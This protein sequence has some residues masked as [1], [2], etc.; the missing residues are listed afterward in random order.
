MIFCSLIFIAVIISLL[1]L[2]GKI[3]LKYGLLP[4]SY[5]ILLF[6]SSV[7]FIIFSVLFFVY[8]GIQEKKHRVNNCHLKILN[9]VI[10]FGR[11][12]SRFNFKGLQNLDS[13]LSSL[14]YDIVEFPQFPGMQRKI[15]NRNFPSQS[16]STE[17]A[18]RY[19]QQKFS[20]LK[21]KDSQLKEQVSNFIVSW[22]PMI[23]YKVDQEIYSTQKLAYSLEDLAIQSEQF[24]VEQQSYIKSLKKL[25]GKLHAIQSFLDPLISDF[26]QK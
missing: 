25:Q 26:E 6:V 23:S 5:G 11:D 21:T 22:K 9:Q 4:K 17:S 24:V 2:N 3:T 18:V 12:N 1:L 19:F 13:F 20:S 15:L 14:T 16:E 10:S 8:F 7:I